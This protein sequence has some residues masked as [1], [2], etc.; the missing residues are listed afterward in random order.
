ME[1]YLTEDENKFE[2]SHTTYVVLIA[3]VFTI[4]IR[5]GTYFFLLQVHE[6]LV[7]K[8]N[9]TRINFGTRTQTAI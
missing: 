2:S 5:I 6:S 8:K 4:C 9:D 3:I 7:L 1:F